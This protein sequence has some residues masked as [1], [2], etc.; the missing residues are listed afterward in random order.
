MQLKI[1]TS[2]N[3]LYPRAGIFIKSA[4]INYWAS[5][6]E[7]MGIALH[8][9]FVYPIPHNEPNSIWGCLVLLPNNQKITELGRNSFCQCIENKIFLPEYSDLYPKVSSEEIT[10]LCKRNSFVVHPDFGFV[11]L[12]EPINWEEHLEIAE[13]IPCDFKEVAD[14][15]FI[16]SSVN[17]F[18]IKPISP[19]EV[20]NNLEDKY[21]PKAEQLQNKPLSFIEQAKLNILKTL[22]NKDKSAESQSANKIQNTQLMNLLKGAI[23]TFANNDNWSN[24]LQNEYENLEERNKKQLEKLL[25]LFKNN[26]DEALK[27][28]IPLDANGSNRG[29]NTGSLDLFRRWND[30]S[31]FH[32]AG[33]FSQGGGSLVMPNEAFNQ[34]YQQYNKTAQELIKNK[35][36]LKASFV[37]IKL[38]QNYYL[39]AK[40]LEDGG[41]YLEAASIY[42]K[43]ACSKAKAA[44]CYEKANVLLKAIEL[45]EE[46]RMYE[47]VGD[48]HL[49][50]ND[51]ELA[52]KFYRKVL[53][54]YFENKEYIKA[55]LFC[56]EKMSNLD[57]AQTI[58]LQGWDENI[59]ADKSLNLY[60][61]NIVD[62]S[63]LQSEMLR[64]YSEIVVDNKREI[65]L[66]TLENLYGKK[67]EISDSIKD[68]AHEI[69]STQVSRNPFLISKLKNFERNDKALMRDIIRFKKRKKV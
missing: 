13:A 21:F 67:A 54:R 53:D 68:L 37:Y 6:I 24:K 46:L 22:F 47:K 33:T 5:E 65:F 32:N 11:A 23:S 42:L 59:Q 25:D 14:S 62:S 63:L 2:K 49:Q 12:S 18:Y 29:S 40:T 66:N 69:I 36:Y 31:L 61:Q 52:N 55:A 44:E 1:K 48:L 35:E 51:R 17:R 57:E 38:L 20:L 16:P 3:N 15:L 50:M 4:D 19:D 10:E 27:Y 39:A 34:L 64:L 43:Y 60:M 26:L 8:S 28:A 7:A 9:A 56:R 30:F 45:Y 58:L 41:L